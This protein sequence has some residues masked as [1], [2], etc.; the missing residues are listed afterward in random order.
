[1]GGEGKTFSSGDY[2]KVKKAA[3]KALLSGALDAAVSELSSL[4]GKGMGMGREQVCCVRGREKE[5]ER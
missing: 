5:G 2:Q 1:M 3:A 4:L